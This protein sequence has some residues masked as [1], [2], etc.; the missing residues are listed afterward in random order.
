MNTDINLTWSKPEIFIAKK[1]DLPWIGKKYKWYVY[2]YYLNPETN[3]LEK[4]I[5]TMG[6]NKIMNTNEKI[7]AINN[8][9]TA[10]EL[11]LG[12]SYSPFKSISEPVPQNNLW[13]RPTLQII[14][15]Y[16]KGKLIPDI[17]SDWHISYHFRDPNT[18]KFEAI[19][20]TSY[21]NQIQDVDLRIVAL[22]KERDLLEQKLIN[23]F[24]PFDEK[25]IEEKVYSITEEQYNYFQLLKSA[26]DS[27]SNYPLIF[28][29][30]RNE[31]IFFKFLKDENIIDESHNVI[32][33]NRLSPCSHAF[34]NVT[35]DLFNKNKNVLK[36]NVEKKDFRKFIN[37]HFNKKYTRFSSPIKYES[38]AQDFFN[39][40]SN[41]S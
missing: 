39:V 23:G 11:F 37:N 28:K 29:D 3:K 7:Y 40:V 22:K 21:I 32:K 14:A 10:L 4:F 33:E 35:M 31:K 30:R 25:E 2:Y 24:S 16:V 15:K 1:D 8:L 17:K 6:I 26:N 13:F 9:R 38:D 41:F 27:N 34:Y 36:K 12:D 20:H 18:K 19:K 5:E